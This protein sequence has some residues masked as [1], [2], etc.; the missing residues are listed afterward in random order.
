MVSLASNLAS[1][2]LPRNTLHT[3][4]RIEVAVAGD[5]RQPLMPG[6]GSDPGVVDRDRRSRLLQL[7]PNGSVDGRNRPIDPRHFDGVE[8]GL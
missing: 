1:G 6:D 8:I 4:H 7:E 5:D 2:L 3:A